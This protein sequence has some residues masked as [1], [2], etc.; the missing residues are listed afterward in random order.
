MRR[1]LVAAAIVLASATGAFATPSDDVGHAFIAL[2]AATSYH[3]AIQARGQ[4]MDIDMLKP[5]K[6]H[7][8][9]AQME[10][11]SIAGAAYVKVN[12]TWM[13]LPA[14]MP[15]QMQNVGFGYVQTLAN[16][17]PNDVTVEDLGPKSVDGATYHAYKVTPKDG[18][19]SNVYLD[20]SG[21]I[22]RCDVT[23][24]SGTSI[25]RFSKFNAPISIDAPI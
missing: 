15:Q 13:K 17:K 6:I 10:M 18:K 2:G 3:V 20:G 21:V 5:N 24:R 22:A 7:M 23:D 14:A 1:S 8:M 19:V 25:I 4:T 9:T 11:I 12:G 16:S